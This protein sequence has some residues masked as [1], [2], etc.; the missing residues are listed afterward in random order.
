MIS[1]HLQILLVLS[2]NWLVVTSNSWGQAPQIVVEPDTLDFGTTIVCTPVSRELTISN[3]GNDTLELFE[4]YSN[5]PYFPFSYTQMSIP[6]GDQTLLN[7]VFDGLINT[8]GIYEGYLIIISNDPVNDTLM[9]PMKVVVVEAPQI[10][11]YQEV[12]VSVVEGDSLNLQIPFVFYKPFAFSWYTDIEYQ[13]NVLYSTSDLGDTLFAVDVTAR[14]PNL[15]NNLRGICYDRDIFWIAGANASAGIP[16]LYKFDRQW[17]LINSFPQ[18]TAAGNPFGFSE[19]ASDGVFLYGDLNNDIYVFDVNSGVLITVTDLSLLPRIDAFTID[20]HSLDIWVTAWSQPVYRFDFQGTLL[21]SIPY[22]G[23]LITGLGLDRFSGSIPYLWAWTA[24]GPA[25]GPNCTAVQLQGSTLQFIGV[26]MNSDPLENDQ[27][28]GMDIARYDNR[29]ALLAIQQSNNL[30]GDGHDFLVGYSL[31][32]EWREW[33]VV[34]PD[35]GTIPACANQDLDLKFYG[36]RSQAGDTTRHAII[37][38]YNNDPANPEI[39]WD[40]TMRVE[41]ITGLV[42]TPN[43]SPMSFVLYQNYPNPF[44]SETMITFVLPEAGEVTLD[45]YNIL[46]QKILTIFHDHFTGGRQ[47]FRWNGRDKSG[48]E[49]PSGIYFYQLKTGRYEMM[50]KMMILR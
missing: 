25:Q 24:D 21:S 4:I 47:Y 10:A 6:P 31:G 2:F 42:N 20:R 49:V 29:L 32:H 1:T 48:Q 11:I 40:V 27:P 7:L 19:I 41:S 26:E 39:I 23:P 22:S 13:D 35:S 38:F 37:T 36:I 43:N 30:P 3:T 45:I 18:P 9:I 34:S 28:A 17:N 5:S 14:I 12:N 33:L 15:D 44:N 8:Q 50:K 46:G 16:M